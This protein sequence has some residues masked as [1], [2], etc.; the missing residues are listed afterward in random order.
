MQVGNLATMH[1]EKS[2][3]PKKS[4]WRARASLGLVKRAVSP[5]LADGRM[6]QGTGRG[7]PSFLSPSSSLLLVPGCLSRSPA[8][9]GTVL[10]LSTVTRQPVATTP[11]TRAKTLAVERGK[12]GRRRPHQLVISDSVR[13][14]LI[15]RG[16]CPRG[17]HWL[18]AAECWSCRGGVPG[19][20]PV[21]HLLIALVRSPRRPASHLLYLMSQTFS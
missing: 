8:L 7:P 21:L 19:P 6:V 5:C 4:I 11:R 14:K 2:C 17:P 3:N 18:A 13:P 9:Q 16:G 15:R 10:G 20:Y 12:R 1:L